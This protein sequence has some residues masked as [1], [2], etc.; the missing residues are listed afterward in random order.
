MDGVKKKWYAIFERKELIYIFLWEK[1]NKFKRFHLILPFTLSFYSTIYPKNKFALYN[2]HFLMW[3]SQKKITK[4]G[5][6]TG[7]P[8]KLTSLLESCNIVLSKK[9]SLCD[10]FM[11]TKKLSSLSSF[12]TKHHFCM[13]LFDNKSYFL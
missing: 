1:P 5:K 4:K 7:Q 3:K 12:L 8:H 6:I 10:F 2:N 13:V 11:R 9:C